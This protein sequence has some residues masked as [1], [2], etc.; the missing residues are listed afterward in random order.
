[1]LAKM[2]DLAPQVV[3]P[4]NNWCGAPFSQLF[5]DELPVVDRELATFAAER[6]RYQY[7]IVEDRLNLA[8]E[9]VSPLHLAHWNDMSALAATSTRDI[10]YYTAL[11]PPFIDAASIATQVRAL[12]LRRVI[13]ERAEAFL[14]SN[15]LGPQGFFGVQIRKTDFG[16]NGADDQNLFE[17][18]HKTAHKRFFVCSDDK[19]VEERF[20][21]LP[22]AVIHAK[23]AH[24]EKLV[25]GGW[26]TPTSDHSGRVYACN[27]NRSGQ[28]V[29]DALV[30]LLILSHSQVVKTSNSTFLN[31]ALLLQASRR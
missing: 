6:D 2:L 24:V 15:G 11:I 23:T 31:T 1:V 19:A 29:I 9:W 13:V 3:W 22:N 17:L 16:G 25:D 14:R 5:E 4:V 10:F 27:V 20:K 26:N 8:R 21:A 28:S 7:L 30:D 12:H 18:V